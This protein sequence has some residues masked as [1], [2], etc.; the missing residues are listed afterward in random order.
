[1]RTLTCL[2]AFTESLEDGRQ[3]PLLE[4]SRVVEVSGLAL[5][6]GQVMPGIENMPLRFVRSF[7]VGDHGTVD[8]HFDPMNIG[9]HRRRLKREPARDAVS[10]MVERD[11]LILVDLARLLDARIERMLR[12]RQGLLAFHLKTL[13]NRLRFPGRYALTI[14]VTAIK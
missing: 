11:G 13:S 6:N 2:E 9:F 14:F 10:D 7:V 3:L 12:Q 4:N 1:M 8:D 5:E